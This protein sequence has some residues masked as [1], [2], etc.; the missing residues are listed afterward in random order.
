M[1]GPHVFGDGRVGL[2][3]VN[4]GN[5]PDRLNTIKAFANGMI[6]DVFMPQSSYPT[7]MN[8]L[9]SN[10]LNAHLWTVPGALSEQAYAAQVLSNINRLAP[11]AVEL[12]IEVEDQLLGPYVRTVLGALR[13]ARP[14]YRFRVN[15]AP[16]KA[17]FLPGDLIIKAPH[18]YLAEQT[19]YGDMSRVSEGEALMD[20]LDAGVPL[21]KCSLCYGAAMPLPGQVARVPS[22]P[23]LFYNDRLVRKLRRGIIFQDDLM[24]EMGML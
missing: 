15:I 8:L 19:Y 22:L 5:L 16:Y 17:S 11:G 7:D 23:T 1:S 12:N 3:V 14:S 20:M 4:P 10:G 2:W 9:R 13:F 18:L 24:V 6:T 21:P